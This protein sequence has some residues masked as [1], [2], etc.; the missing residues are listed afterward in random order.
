MKKA[1]ALLL[2]LSVLFSFCACDFNDADEGIKTVRDGRLTVALSPDFAPMEFVDVTKEGQDRYVGFD[3]TLAKFIAENLRLQLVL[4]PMSFEACHKA[5]ADG[6]VDLSISGFIWSEERQR[7]FNLSDHYYATVNEDAQVLITL[8]VN[9]DRYA[10]AEGLAGARIGAQRSSIQKDLAIEQLSGSDL[11]LFPDLNEAV[12][13]LLSGEYDCLA[14]A[15]G[16]ADAIIA[17]HPEIAKSGFHFEITEKQRGNV[18]LLPKGSDELTE[19]VN[20]ILKKAQMYY[21]T[22]YADARSTAGI[23]TSYDDDGNLIN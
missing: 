16:N 21:D 2:C 20:N 22:W 23:E 10:T 7:D 15:E 6:T 14:V 12:E 19:R 5:V 4:V 13:Q 3:I 9:G 18:I 17:A 1:F 8:A 11:S